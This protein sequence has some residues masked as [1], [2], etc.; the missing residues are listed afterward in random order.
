MRFH[1]F[2]RPVLAPLALVLLLA[3]GCRDDAESP[4][5]PEADPGPGAAVA[6]ALPT[7]T[8]IAAG[9]LHT[10]AIDTGGSA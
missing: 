6:A 1:P 7:F 10:C 8:T 3:P 9:G 2:L 5:G 4:T